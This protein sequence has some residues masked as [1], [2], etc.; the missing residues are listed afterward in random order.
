MG[1]PITDN[2]RKFPFNHYNDTVSRNDFFISDLEM[3][4]V[5]RRIP[6]NKRLV[7]HGKAACYLGKSRKDAAFRRHHTR[8]YVGA[9][10]CK[11]IALSTITHF[12]KK[13]RCFTDVQLLE[14]H[15]Y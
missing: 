6:L 2:I 15:W 8:M 4:M 12:L 3:Y 11:K 13:F 9:G 7:E 1:L 5:S 10:R 14:I